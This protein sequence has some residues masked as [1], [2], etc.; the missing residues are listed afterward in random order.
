[1]Y[2]YKL[3]LYIY[4]R[5]CVCEFLFEK[6]HALSYK[7]CTKVI[8]VIS[9]VGIVEEAFPDN[10]YYYFVVYIL[11]ISQFMYLNEFIC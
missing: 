3:R 9:T 10:Y 6:N 1:M 8:I 4:T 5:P 11:C 7:V 2:V